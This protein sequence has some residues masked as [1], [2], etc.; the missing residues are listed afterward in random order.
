[1]PSESQLQREYNLGSGHGVHTSSDVR[2]VLIRAAR[3]W[4]PTVTRRNGPSNP[5]E[6][7]CRLRRLPTV[8]DRYRAVT[9]PRIVAMVRGGGKRLPPHFRSW[10]ACVSGAWRYETFHTF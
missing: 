8:N 2:I 4:R 5:D 6:G 9:V 10:L 7:A 3:V 1:M